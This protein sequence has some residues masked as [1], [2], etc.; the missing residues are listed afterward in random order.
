MSQ[1]SPE[2]G[3]HILLVHLK[4]DQAHS[5]THSILQS[6]EHDNNSS[7]DTIPPAHNAAAAHHSQCVGATAINDP[8]NNTF[9]V[10]LLIGR[11]RQITYCKSFGTAKAIPS[12][13][14][15]RSR[16]LERLGGCRSYQ[17]RSN[18]LSTHLSVLI[19]YC[20]HFVCMVSR[21]HK[22]DVGKKT[23]SRGHYARRLGNPRRQGQCTGQNRRPPHS[24]VHPFPKL[25]ESTLR[26]RS[27]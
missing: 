20:N 16:S 6:K 18:R 10:T 8:S 23:R 17:R 11:S 21:F 1:V 22:P 2:L 24:Y 19:L 25:S 5:C 13:S 3:G 4:D 14:A 9:G 12:F 27:R 15:R 7:S 26:C